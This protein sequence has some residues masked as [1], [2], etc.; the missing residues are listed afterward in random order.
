VQGHL[1]ELATD[2]NAIFKRCAELNGIAQFRVYWYRC[3]V[4]TDPELAGALLV[5]EAS[6]FM[7]TRALQAARPTFGNGLVT[8]EGE[9]WRRQQRLLRPFLTPRA[10]ATYANLVVE[11]VD[12]KRARW[13][14]EPEVDLHAEMVDVSLEVVCRGLFGLDAAKVQTFIREAA[15]G[16][17]QW[18]S[19]CEALCLPFPHYMPTYENFRYRK[20]TRALD[21][22]VYAL[23]RDTRESGG[24]GHA[25]LG[26]M[27]RIK[28]EDGTSIHD[29]EIRDQVVTLF[30]AGHDTTASSLA[31]ALYELGYRP[32]LQA[33]IAAG[34]T[35]CLEQVLKE[36]LR[37]YPAVHLIARTALRDV[38][39][40]PYLVR[41][42]E[43]VVVPL[44]V[45]HRSPRLFPRPDD[46]E[47]ERWAGSPEQPPC[48]RHAH[49]P[50][51]TGPRV[52]AG[53]AVANVELR[54]AVS[55]VL[56]HFRLAPLG[57]RAPRVRSKMT[58]TPAPGSTRVRFAPAPAMKDDGPAHALQEPLG[59]V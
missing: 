38:E 21:R 59:G 33:R 54:A 17:Q 1:R 48:H 52:C 24:D 35:E 19:D 12:K 10:A 40:G 14:R 4:I 32:D 16:V 11:A 39:L 18:H 57:P 42:G 34:D 46:F 13:M 45:M 26:A 36:T 43:E 28:D 5:A 58:I 22:A 7:K 6:A 51:S 31:F 56:R 8:A 27:L 2:H 55:E 29:R 50:F 44:Y 49:L 37:L 20:K 23:I 25:L 30:L 3:N 47:P 9:A 53:Q 15:E 41:R